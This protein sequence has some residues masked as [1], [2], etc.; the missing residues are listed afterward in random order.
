MGSSLDHFLKFLVVGTWGFV[1]NTVVLIFGVRLGLSPSLSG[2][3]GAEFAIVSNFLLNNFWT[4]SDRKITS[5][6]IMVPKFIE[7]NLLSLGSVVI[8]FIFLKTGE[9]IIGEANYKMPF[10]NDPRVSSTTLVK[11]FLRFPLMSR[12]A[13]KVSSYL[14]FYVAGVAVGLIVNFLV[15]NFIIWK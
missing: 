11:A 13:K 15:Y 12:L 2:P 10:I 9:K 3:V 14:I 1:V 5:L 8:Q 7:F 6:D 4:F